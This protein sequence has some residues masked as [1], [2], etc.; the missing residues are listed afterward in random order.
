[1]DSDRKWLISFFTVMLLVP[2]ILDLGYYG[3][4]LTII[5]SWSTNFDPYVTEIRSVIAD[6]PGYFTGLER[7]GAQNFTITL[8]M[9]RT[10]AGL[11]V[12]KLNSQ[13]LVTASVVL[14]VVGALLLYQSVG[15]GDPPQPAQ[16]QPPQ[17]ASST[18]P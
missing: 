8:S 13:A 11:A 17:P 14:V 7:A 5:S 3:Y 12:S 16:V 15:N 18:P 1:M 9:A 2:L 10:A 6:N 4:R